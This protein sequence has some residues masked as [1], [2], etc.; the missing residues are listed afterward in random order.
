MPRCWKL[1]PTHNPLAGAAIFNYVP[2]CL[3]DDCWEAT[4]W[5]SPDLDHGDTPVATDELE[6]IPPTANITGPQDEDDFHGVLLAEQPSH[7]D[8][9]FNILY[10]D[11]N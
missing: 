3:G 5:K 4:S 10:P 1:L 7:F 6:D 8:Y 9:Y 11:C 2:L